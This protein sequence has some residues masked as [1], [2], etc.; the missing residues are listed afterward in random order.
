MYMTTNRTFTS[1]TEIDFFAGHSTASLRKIVDQKTAESAYVAMNSGADHPI[2]V[3]MMSIA[4][5]AWGQL[6]LR[7]ET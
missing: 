7:G 6:V 1:P 2:A 5:A 4:N 3:E